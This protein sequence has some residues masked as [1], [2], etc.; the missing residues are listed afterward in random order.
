M[1][2]RSTHAKDRHLPRPTPAPEVALR[3][4]RKTDAKAL[5]GLSVG[6]IVRP[7]HVAAAFVEEKGEEAL[8]HVQQLVDSGVFA[9]VQ[10]IP[11]PEPAPVFGMNRAIRRA[12]DRRLRRE[13]PRVAQL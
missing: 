4:M 9:L 3:Y 7:E 6:D 2:K 1:G 11:E 8:R 12:Q 10:V 13:K 5:V